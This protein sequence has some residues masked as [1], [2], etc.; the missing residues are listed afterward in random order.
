MKIDTQIINSHLS[1]SY[2][3]PTRMNFKIPQNY[4]ID[5]L[6]FSYYTNGN[7]P[8]SGTINPGTNMAYTVDNDTIKFSVGQLYQPRGGN[9][10]LPDE[11]YYTYYTLYMTPTCRTTNGVAQGTYMQ[12][13]FEFFGP[14]QSLASSAYKM[15]T[16]IAIINGTTLA[17]FHPNI[18]L[19]SSLQFLQPIQN[20]YLGLCRLVV[21]QHLIHLTIGYILLN[22]S[23]F[24]C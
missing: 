11:A 2:G 18:I 5:S 17:N 19:S 23:D 1:A 3:F 12:D 20:L 10:I 4:L 9:I 16:T 8:Y 15:G 6:E 22:H 24:K 14:L 21:Y 7:Q 13:S